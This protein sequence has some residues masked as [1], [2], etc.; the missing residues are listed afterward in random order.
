MYIL[1][2]WNGMGYSDMIFWQLRFL[3]GGLIFSFFLPL[4]V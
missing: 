2:E 1:W 3:N 4:V